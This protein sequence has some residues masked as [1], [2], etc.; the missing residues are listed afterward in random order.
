MLKLGKL[1]P[2]DNDQESLLASV[3]A[4]YADLSPASSNTTPSLA[5]AIEY[6]I[7]HPGSLIRARIAW[8]I[9]TQLG[10]SNERAKHIAIAVE[11]FHT[12]SLLLDDLPSMDNASLRRGS[13][14]THVC[15]GEDL[16]ILAALAFINRAY[17]LLW[18]EMAHLQMHESQHISDFIEKC[19]GTSGILS[20]QADDIHFQDALRSSKLITKIATN[21]TVTLLRLSFCLPAMIAGAPRRKIDLLR[22]LALYRGIAYQMVDDFKDI[23]LS[24]ELSGKTSDRDSH[25]T[26]PNIVASEGVSVAGQML[27][28]LVEKGDRIQQELAGDDAEWGFLN[29]LRLTLGP[30]LLS[31]SS[32]LL[33]GDL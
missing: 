17:A 21:K 10:L 22:R 11:Y 12:A 5:R 1:P 18:R 3:R 32:I 28:N 7:A 4:A 13:P 25:L 24:E 9:G 16:T 33:S 27:M 8:Q 20:G 15:Y 14:C 30:E 2:L 23:F 31:E 6:A 19:L 29:A 26:R